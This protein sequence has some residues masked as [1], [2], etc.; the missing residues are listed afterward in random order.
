MH[1]VTL[2]GLAAL[3]LHPRGLDQGLVACELGFQVEQAESLGGAR[4]TFDA[5]RVGD[6]APQHLEAA[7]QTQQPAAPAQMGADIEIPALR[8]DHGEVGEGR[9]GTGQDN[10]VG[11][12]RQGPAA[13]HESDLHV[14]LGH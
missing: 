7:A 13:R 5:I 9:L 12:A 6:P 11:I 10:E 1:L 8:P 3:D 14:R 2:N 4:R